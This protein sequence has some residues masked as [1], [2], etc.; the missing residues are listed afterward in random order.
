MLLITNMIEQL[1]L[2]MSA[3]YWIEQNE[4]ANFILS[5]YAFVAEIFKF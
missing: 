5:F 4:C 1:L 3:K 2:M